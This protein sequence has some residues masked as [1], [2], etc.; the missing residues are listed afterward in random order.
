MEVS[1]LASE[2]YGGVG[3]SALKL[4]RCLIQHGLDSQ[5]VYGSGST[6]VPSVPGLEFSVRSVK[7]QFLNSGEG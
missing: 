2:L 7:S 6:S 3:L 5:P 4:H 1:H